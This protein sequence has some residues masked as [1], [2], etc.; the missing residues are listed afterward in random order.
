MDREWRTRR[1]GTQRQVGKRFPVRGGRGGT[2]HRQPEMTIWEIDDERIAKEKKET[3]RL[4]ELH[5]LLKWANSDHPTRRAFA[6][7]ELKHKFPEEYKQFLEHVK[8]M[9]MKKMEKK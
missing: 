5:K 3:E 7:A 6:I 9:E 8:E 2:P 1:R 4:L